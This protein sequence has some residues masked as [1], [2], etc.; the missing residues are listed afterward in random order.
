MSSKKMPFSVGLTAM[1]FFAASMSSVTC[2]HNGVAASNN[3]G[4][5]IDFVFI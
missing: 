1:S 4:K 3:T 5:I 2:A